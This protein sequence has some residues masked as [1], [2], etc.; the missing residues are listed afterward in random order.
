MVRVAIDVDNLFVLPLFVPCSEQVELSAAVVQNLEMRRVHM[1][2]SQK[3]EKRPELPSLGKA[4]HKPMPWSPGEVQMKSLSSAPSRPPPLPPA[5]ASRLST[6]RLEAMDVTPLD[7]PVR[8]HRA[9]NVMA[10]P[11]IASLGRAE[12]HHSALPPARV[13]EGI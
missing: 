7:V 5:Q 4:A 11:C 13:D 10:L 12:R 2:M 6:M 8:R 9:D 1:M 3:N